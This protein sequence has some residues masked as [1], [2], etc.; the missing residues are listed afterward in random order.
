MS[1]SY[2]SRIFRLRSSQHRPQGVEAR[3]QAGDLAGIEV[4]RAGQLLVGQLAHAAVRQQVLEGR[5]DQVRRRLRRA[6]EVLGIV[7]LVGVNDAAETFA[8]M[9]HAIAG[10]DLRDQLR[11]R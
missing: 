7:L 1:V 3:A 4:D 9:V 6:G 10:L 5:R 8:V 11:H 2:V